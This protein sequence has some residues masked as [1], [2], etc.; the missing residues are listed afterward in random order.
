MV[1]VA[2]GSEK[3]WGGEVLGEGI[4]CHESFEGSAGGVVKGFLVLN[5]K[6]VFL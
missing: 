3:S 2:G 4:G 1:W 6:T 5:R